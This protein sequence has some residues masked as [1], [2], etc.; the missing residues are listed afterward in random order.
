[1]WMINQHFNWSLIGMLDLN[2]RNDCIHVGQFQFLLYNPSP[3]QLVLYALC[4]AMYSCLL[5]APFIFHTSAEGIPIQGTSV[6]PEW[7]YDGAATSDAKAYASCQWS[8]SMACAGAHVRCGMSDIQLVI[9]LAQW[10]SLTPC[11]SLVQYAIPSRLAGHL[12][13]VST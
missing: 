2:T 9:Q 4:N 8:D 11:H 7:I 12:E 13:F 5:T 10:S 1:M 6:T 3:S